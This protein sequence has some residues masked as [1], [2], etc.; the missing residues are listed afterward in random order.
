MKIETLGFGMRGNDI[1]KELRRT[2]LHGPLGESPREVV[3]E[4]AGQ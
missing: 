2:I 3:R 4:S 1:N